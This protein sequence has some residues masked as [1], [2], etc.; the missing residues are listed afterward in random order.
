MKIIFEGNVKKD[1]NILNILNEDLLLNPAQA[2][3]KLNSYKL[4]IDKIEKVNGETVVFIKENNN[5]LI[6][7]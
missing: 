6:C 4:T 3:L 1:K 7:G 2:N 5:N